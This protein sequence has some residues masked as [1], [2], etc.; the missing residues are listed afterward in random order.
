MKHYRIPRWL[1]LIAL[2]SGLAA[3]SPGCSS[4]YTVSSTGK[5]DAEYSHQEMIEELTGRDVTIQLKDGRSIL[6]KE[7]KISDDSVSWVDRETNKESR[8]G[9]GQIKTIVNKNHLVG[10]LEGLGFGVVGGGGL[11]ALIGNSLNEGGGDFGSG[12]GA[13]IGLILGGGTGI[14]VGSTT[15]A[16]IG[17]SYNYEF[18]MSAQTDSLQNGK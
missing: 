8:A 1:K 7:V 17:H 5:P 2:L 18:P 12:F 9:I 11:G 3:F 13:V 15:G 6:A 10:F 16:T 4:S 14:L